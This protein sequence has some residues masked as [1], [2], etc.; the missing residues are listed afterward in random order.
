MFSLCIAEEK[1]KIN[2]RYVTKVTVIREYI[3]VLI[4]RRYNLE[5]V[6]M[7]CRRG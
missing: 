7:T 4:S 5:G 2:A 1:V 6:C 3:L